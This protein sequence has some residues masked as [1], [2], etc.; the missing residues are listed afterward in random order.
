MA[1]V[2]DEIEVID[3]TMTDATG[4]DA[5]SNTEVLID[6]NNNI[7]DIKYCLLLFIMLWTI[8]SCKK[9]IHNAIRAYMDIT[10]K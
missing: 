4:T 1:R 5:Y 3:G 9:I 6:I 7:L 10:K 8:L 2:I